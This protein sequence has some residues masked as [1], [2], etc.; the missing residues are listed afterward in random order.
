[1]EN[2]SNTNNRQSTQKRSFTHEVGRT[3]SELNQNQ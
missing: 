3:E 2:K 1:M